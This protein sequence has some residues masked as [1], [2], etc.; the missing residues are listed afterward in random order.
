VEIPPQLLAQTP[1]SSHPA[2]ICQ[3]C[4][5]SFSWQAIQAGDF[6]FDSR[7]LLVLTA[8]YHLRRGYCCGNKCR[9]CPFDGVTVE[10]PP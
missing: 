10:P 2:C 9:H 5:R 6:Y 1:K 4:V 3:G 8:E 7:G